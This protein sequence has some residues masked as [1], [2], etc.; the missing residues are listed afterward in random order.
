MVAKA[1][2]YFEGEELAVICPHCLAKSTFP[3]WGGMYT[4]I[5]DKCGEAV[6]VEKTDSLIQ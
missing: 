2:A 4:Y 3:D 5:C 6:E 1:K